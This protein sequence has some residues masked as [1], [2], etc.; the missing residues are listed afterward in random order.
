MSHSWG[1]FFHFFGVKF[2]YFYFFENTLASALK[3]AK[4]WVEFEC[5][6]MKV[7]NKDLDCGFKKIQE[8]PKSNFYLLNIKKN[9]YHKYYIIEFQ[10]ITY[11]Y[12]QKSHQDDSKMRPSFKMSLL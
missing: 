5:K 6:Y 12:L 2:F 10:W 8:E 11:L 3:R 1:P 7:W 9:M 4:I